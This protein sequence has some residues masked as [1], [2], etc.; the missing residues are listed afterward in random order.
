MMKGGEYVIDFKRAAKGSDLWV[1]FNAVDFSADNI[2]VFATAYRT[3]VPIAY[4]VKGDT[5]VFR[6]SHDGAL[7]FSYRLIGKRHDWKDWPTY[8]KDQEETPSFPLLKS[9]LFTESEGK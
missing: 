6:S 3:P 5:I 8:A 9:K 7:S 1:W 2:E 4:E